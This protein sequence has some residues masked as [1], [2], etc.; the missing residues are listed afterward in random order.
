MAYAAC[1][2][3]L[4][5]AALHFYWALGGRAGL[6]DAPDITER[7]WFLVYDVVAGILSLVAAA[8][9]MALVQPWGGMVPGG[10]YC[11]PLGVQAWCWRC[12]V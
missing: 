9:A 3:G 12:G 7:T 10:C 11:W 4:L 6:G 5:F 8:V 2:W 1:A